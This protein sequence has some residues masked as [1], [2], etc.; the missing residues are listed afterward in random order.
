MKF[1]SK[2]I[3]AA[4][5]TGVL[6]SCSNDIEMR[7]PPKFE[8]PDLP[9]IS[10]IHTYKAPMYWS[11]YEYCYVN[12]QNGVSNSDQDI[13][14][15]EWDRIL[16]WVSATSSLT[17]TTWCARTASSPCLRRTRAAI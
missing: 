6:C 14:P 9:E 3:G 8:L 10:N 5:L 4:A 16:D 15:E 1:I 13:S 12:E 2:I 11:V 7:R 17:A